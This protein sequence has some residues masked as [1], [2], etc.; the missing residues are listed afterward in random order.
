MIKTSAGALKTSA[1]R[2]IAVIA[3]L[4]LVGSACAGPR[5]PLEVG[6]KEF[7]SDVVLGS[8]K[9][10]LATPVFLPPDALP[11]S[12]PLLPA[13]VSPPPAFTTTTLPPLEACPS[14]DPLSA[15]KDEALSSV[16]FPPAAGSYTFRNNGTFEVSGPNAQKGVF[17]ELSTRTIKNIEE[18]A[19]GKFTYDVESVLGDTT[20][21][22]SYRVEPPNGGDISGP[23]LFIAKIS[24]STRGGEVSTFDPTPDL[25]LL[26]FPIEIGNEFQS[27]GVDQRTGTAMAFSVTVGVKSRVD[28]CGQF[29]DAHTA[30]VNGRISDCDPTLP[31][32]CPPVPPGQQVSPDEATSFTAVYRVGTQY[33]GITLEEEVVTDTDTGGVRVH[34]ENIATISAVP[35]LSRGAQ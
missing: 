6:L 3:V 4:A 33:G 26:K 24:S 23:G 8:Q 29:L 13:G 9:E 35:L 2:R 14:A 17:P 16:P 11:L 15:P 20:T 34:R 10:D 1:H 28:A 22:T 25:A 18:L 27:L 32:P 19:P 7:P 31:A 12:T 21:V 5:E 30:T